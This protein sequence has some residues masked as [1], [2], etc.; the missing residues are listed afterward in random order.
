[1]NT[2]DISER[3]LREVYLP[4]F[5][6]AFDAGAGSV[7]SSFNEIGGVP[8]TCNAFT[9][10]TLLRDE[11]RWPG[12]VVSDY[13]AVC[14]LIQHGVA[15]DLKDAARLSILAGLDMDM[16]SGAYAQHLAA[17]VDEG[18]VP[19]QLVDEAVRR[20]LRLKFAL[21]LFEHPYTDETL[22]SQMILRDDF[23]AQ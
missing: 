7:M 15:A 9:L 8:S 16:V 6:A 17:L 19:E 5:K 4:P 11:W 12:V 14:E 3:T 23:R 13:E 20:V 18:A 22:A 1:Y 10:R 21:G 2:V